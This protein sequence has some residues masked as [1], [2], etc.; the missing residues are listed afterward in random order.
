[1]GLARFEVDA[2]HAVTVAWILLD[3]PAAEIA[4]LLVAG[5]LWLGFAG[6]GVVVVAS[7]RAEGSGFLCEERGE[8]LAARHVNFGCG[9]VG[10]DR[11]LRGG[12]GACGADEDG[13][14][15]D[16]EL[17]ACL[18]AE[19]AEGFPEWDGFEVEGEVVAWLE[20]GG[21]PDDE[22]DLHGILRCGQRLELEVVEGVR[23]VGVLEADFG[24]DLGLEL[25]LERV[26]EGRGRLLGGCG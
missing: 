4:V 10:G 11:W 5:A 6:G 20:V 26:L 13:V 19:M 3:R 16:G 22:G 25:L 7:G 17:D 23:E 14:L 2:V 24:E 1:M 15:R 9:D 21:Q 8:F 18:A 12:L